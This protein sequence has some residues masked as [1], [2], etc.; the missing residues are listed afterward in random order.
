MKNR[1]AILFFL[2]WSAVFALALRF[3]PDSGR[4]SAASSGSRLS[5]LD[6]R[7]VVRIDV[8]RRMSKGV[9]IENVAV[10]RVNGRWCI[11]SPVQAEADE[12]SVKRLTDAILFAESGHG[13]S[14]SDMAALGRSLRDFGLAA[15]RCTVTISDGSVHDSFS[16][17]R[18]TAAGDEVCRLVYLCKIDINVTKVY[19]VHTAADIH[20]H[21]CR[22]DL[23]RDSHGS[24]NSTPLT[25]VNIGHDP[26]L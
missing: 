17:G 21:H 12:A 8:S 9:G 20:A 14:E 10:A 6:A 7:E 22:D 26:D 19:G 5:S 3:L 24:T 11:E 23:V 1:R 16:V 25:C 4:S 15:P 13:L 2:F 18:R